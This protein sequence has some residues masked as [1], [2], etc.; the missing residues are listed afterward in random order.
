MHQQV[1]CYLL[2]YYLTFSSDTAKYSNVPGVALDPSDSTERSEEGRHAMSVV[3]ARK[4][5]ETSERV[6]DKRLINA[7]QTLTNGPAALKNHYAQSILLNDPK[8]LVEWI[9]SF[10]SEELP[11]RQDPFCGGAVRWFSIH[12][13]ALRT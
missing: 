5:T 7:K 3:V 4:A 10:Q 13:V 6:K 1:S 2:K 9:C 8:A 12:R 11:L